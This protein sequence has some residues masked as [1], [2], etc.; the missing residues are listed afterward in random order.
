M[1]HAESCTARYKCTSNCN[2]YVCVC[3]CAGMVSCRFYQMTGYS[4]DEVL[5]H[6]WC[7]AGVNSGDAC[8]ED[9]SRGSSRGNSRDRGGTRQAVARAAAAE[10]LD[11]VWSDL[12]CCVCTQQHTSRQCTD[13]P[14]AMMGHTSRG[15]WCSI[16]A[17]STDRPSCPSGRQTLHT[18]SMRCNHC[19][20]SCADKAA[21]A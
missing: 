19:R 18:S 5:G 9:S 1:E 3:V 2:R 15:C 8:R 20:H 12:C 7:V 13:T 6:N 10:S 17:T 4:S 14:G 16:A 11:Y 21:S